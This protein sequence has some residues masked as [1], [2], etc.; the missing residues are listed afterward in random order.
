MKIC[1]IDECER[2][3]SGKGFCT[4]HYHL[5]YKYGD[6]LAN[7]FLEK[8]CIHCGMSFIVD[9]A[10]RGN[11]RYCENCRVY[12]ICLVEGCEKSVVLRDNKPA[13]KLCP[14]HL[15][16][17]REGREIE[18][19][20]KEIASKGEGS[21]KHGYRYIQ[22]DNISKAEHRSVMEDKI[23]RFLFPKEN[24]HHLNGDKLDNRIEN[25]EL[26]ST[27]QPPGQ[28]VEDKIK[29]AKEFLLQY[30]SVEDLMLWLKEVE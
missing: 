18:G 8:I 11:I 29:W 23:G 13:G 22:S 1:S 20:I 6:P 3:V 2:E 5:W 21:L 4:V 15:Q 16:R 25:L 14:G 26:W 30:Q 19:P 10:L 27:S 12:R 24:V 28:R 7:P 17:K 9:G